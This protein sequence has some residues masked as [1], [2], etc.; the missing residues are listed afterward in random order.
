M[1]VAGLVSQASA[2]QWGAGATVSV[3]SRVEASADPHRS[4]AAIARENKIAA[5]DAVVTEGHITRLRAALRLTPAQ[6]QLWAP[7]E[8]ALVDLARQQARGDAAAFTYKLTDR[9]SAI[10][11]TANQLRRLKV[12]AMPLINSLNDNQKRE[13]RAFAQAMGL[14]HL[15]TAF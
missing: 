1:L 7:V 14:Q 15:A 11:A 4:P 13:A 5:T 8:A 10:A 12:I 6:Q 3:Q 9:S 2:Q